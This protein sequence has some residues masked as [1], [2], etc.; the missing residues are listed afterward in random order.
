MEKINLG[1]NYVDIFVKKYYS[2]YWVGVEIL[3][4]EMDR[5]LVQ[6][7]DKIQ[8]VINGV[9]ITSGNSYYLTLVIK[10]G[11]KRFRIIKFL[12]KDK[13]YNVN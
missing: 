2:L 9:L 3:K 6:E 8:K 4:D 12:T 7:K 10:Q 11:K 1:P 5:K 13:G